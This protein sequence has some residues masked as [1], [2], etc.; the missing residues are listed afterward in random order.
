M[1]RNYKEIKDKKELAKFLHENKKEIITFKRQ[2]NYQKRVFLP[3]SQIKI[4]KT[5]QKADN[6][7]DDSVHIT[8]IINTTYVMD[9]H[10]DV[11][12][13]GLWQKTLQ[14][15][16]DRVY[17]LQEHNPTFAN[18]IVDA[19]DFDIYTKE[20]SWRD[21]GVDAIGSTQALIFEGDIKKERNPLMFRLYKEGNVRQHSVG[22]SYVKLD[23]A[24]LDED[25]T[26]EYKVWKDYIDL[27]INK[28][29][30]IEQGYFWAVKEAKLYE[31]S[32][33]LNGS[34]HITP[35]YAIEPSQKSDTQKGTADTISLFKKIAKY[36]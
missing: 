32:A 25:Y 30:V 12:I 13:N 28:N 6:Q 24:L 4:G 18:V 11:H 22:M 2:M 26:E 20:L 9:S 5:T 35:T 16:K 19:G 17:W 36:Y 29:E 34:N 15:T 3:N 10:D 1:I 8:A 33:V 31:G 7:S 21:L 14:E 27:I 23:L